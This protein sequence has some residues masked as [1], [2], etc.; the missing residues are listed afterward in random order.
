MPGSSLKAEIEFLEISGSEVV[1]ISPDSH[2]KNVM[3]KNPLDPSKRKF[4]AKAGCLQGASY[5]K[6]RSCRSC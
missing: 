1:L 5:P 4:S 3:G 2:S 6:M